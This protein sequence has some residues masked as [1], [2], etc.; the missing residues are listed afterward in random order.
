MSFQGR[1]I[2]VW[3]ERRQL[4]SDK[5]FALY[6]VFSFCF[7]KFMCF[8]KTKKGLVFKSFILISVFVI[9]GLFLAKARGHAV[10]G[11]FYIYGI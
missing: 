4:L 7:M 10:L 9:S 6:V 3:G 8:C 11:H 1:E 5:Q 2:F